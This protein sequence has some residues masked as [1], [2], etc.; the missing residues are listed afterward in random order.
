MIQ[1]HADLSWLPE[2]MIC[3]NIHDFSFTHLTTY[4]WVISPVPTFE[5]KNIMDHLEMISRE[6]QPTFQSTP[7]LIFVN[8][9]DLWFHYPALV[10]THRSSLVL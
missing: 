8:P 9:I 6:N 3:Q 1:R 2:I 7:A 4:D 5:P 10:V